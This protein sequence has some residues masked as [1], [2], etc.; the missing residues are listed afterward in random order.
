MTE[1]AED[2][3]T[4]ELAATLRAFMRGVQDD[5]G[6]VVTGHA[7]R[8]PHQCGCHLEM[9]AAINAERS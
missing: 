8:H 5:N 9:E 3:D 7:C 1:T 2:L 4:L 6:C